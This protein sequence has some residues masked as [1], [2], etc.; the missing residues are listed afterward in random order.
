LAFLDSFIFM[1]NVRHK[2]SLKI[3]THIAIQPEKLYIPTLSIQMLVENA[4]K[5][6]YYSNERPLQI[7]ILSIEEDKI[8]IQN[9]LRER[10]LK[11][12]STKLGILNIKNRYAYYTADRKST[13]LNS[14]HV[15]ISYAVFCLKKKKQRHDV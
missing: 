4:F 15:K 2:D 5:H 10:K 14:S 8:V 11:E 6:N 1:M 7:D 12:E 3:T 13:R 9:S